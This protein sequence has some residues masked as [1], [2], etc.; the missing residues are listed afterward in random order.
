MI[1]LARQDREQGSCRYALAYQSPMKR[2]AVLSTVIVMLGLVMGVRAEDVVRNG[3]R[4]VVVLRVPG[5]GL[6]G[7]AESQL[8]LAPREALA[9]CA[10]WDIKANCCPAGCAAKKGTQWPKADD[11][12][13]GCMRGLGCGEGDVKSA[14]VFMKCDC[15]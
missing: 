13:R 1:F 11:I 6:D 3:D 15:K 10:S 8:T 14:T 2:A 5:D 4:T 12:L 9:S 7:V